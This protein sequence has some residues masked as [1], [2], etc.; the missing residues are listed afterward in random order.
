MILPIRVYG[1]PVLRTP[2][3]RVSG[4]SEELDTLIADM[5]ETMYNAQGVGLAAPQVGRS[6]R[7]FV[8]DIAP[9]LEDES[10]DDS[11]RPPAKLMVFINPDIHWESEEEIDFEEGCLSMP[12]IR[13]TVARPLGLQM[14]FQDHNFEDQSLEIDGPL[15]RVIQHEYDHLEGILFTDRITAFRRT[16][17]KRRLREMAKGDV[18]AEYPLSVSRSKS[19]TRVRAR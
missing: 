2:T 16:M 19:S 14:T 8:V 4:P 12:E 15:A 3:E 1:D 5:A 7:L 10:S 17:L 11:S 18:T 9:L 6:E 13:E